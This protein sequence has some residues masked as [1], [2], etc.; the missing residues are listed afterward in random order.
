LNQWLLVLP[1]F[2]LALVF[3]LTWVAPRLLGV[4]WV[5]SLLLILLA[6]MLLLAAAGVLWQ[7]EGSGRAVVTLMWVLFGVYAL[8]GWGLCRLFE[9]WWPMIT[10]GMLLATRIWTDVGPA[11]AMESDPRMLAVRGV[12]LLG[13]VTVTSFLPLPRL[14]M[15]PEVTRDIKVPGEGIWVDEPHRLLVTGAL[16]FTLIPIVRLY[17]ASGWAF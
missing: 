16:Y 11:L 9:S 1:E 8:M 4:A 17:P 15:T 14:G 5:K 13:V 10:L 12:A 6:E 2:G 7:M 3:L